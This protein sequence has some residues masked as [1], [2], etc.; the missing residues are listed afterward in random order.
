[1]ENITNNIIN[2]FDRSEFGD[3]LMTLI[4]DLN[5]IGCTIQFDNRGK[6]LWIGMEEPVK[7]LG[8]REVACKMVNL[9]IDGFKK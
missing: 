3:N 7:A 5:A 4:D 2:V 6:R 8:S 1:M 9:Y